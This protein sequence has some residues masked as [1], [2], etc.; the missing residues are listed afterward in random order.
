VGHSFGGKVALSHAARTHDPPEEVWVVD[1]TPSAREPRG[2]AV[3]LLEVL[4]AERGPFPT[5]EAAVEAVTRHGFGERVGRFLATNLAEDGQGD[6]RWGLDL[7]GVESLLIDFFHTDLWSAVEDPPGET[8]LH[9]V[10]AEGSEVL[11]EEEC[12]RV[13]AAG[14]AHGRARLHRLPGG[15]WLNVTNQDGLLE[16]MLG[17]TAR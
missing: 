16:L 12:R 8:T 2:D 11:P 6:L 13:E 15:H 10:K 5:R 9:F 17:R 1:S 14:E 4:E 3:R 7:E